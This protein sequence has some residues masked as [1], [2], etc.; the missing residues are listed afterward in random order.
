MSSRVDGAEGRR[1]R[2]DHLDDLERIL[3]VERDGHGID[4]AELGKER[5]FAFHHRQAG[6]R[7]DIAES[8]DA[9]AVGHDSHSIALH[10]QRVGFGW[11]FGNCRADTGDAWCVDHRENIAL[12]VDGHARKHLEL[13]AQVHLERHVGDI[14]DFDKVQLA[15]LLLDESGM[16]R[17]G[18]IDENVADDEI[19]LGTRGIDVASV[20]AGIG[21]G[22]DD[23]AQSSTALLDD[24]SSV[25]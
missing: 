9:R 11:V 13:A 12:A 10:R 21:N 19:V 24:F 7:T 16:I 20:T 4:V 18:G 15:E 5:G 6:Q 25:R 23:L 8:Q 3:R 14:D 22:A 2:L 17:V 1:D